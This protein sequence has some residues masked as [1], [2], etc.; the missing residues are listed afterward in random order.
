MRSKGLFAVRASKAK[1]KRGRSVTVTVSG[2]AAG[3]KVSVRYRGKVVRS[4]TATS[5]GVFVRSIPVGRTLGSAAITAA[6]QFPAIRK[7]ATRIKVV[8]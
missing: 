8:R 6:G 5:T 4:G 2:L 1:V 3:E 7:G